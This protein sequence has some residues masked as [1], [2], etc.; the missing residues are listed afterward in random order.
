MKT[1]SE[2]EMYNL[3]INFAKKDERIRGVLLNGSRANPNIEKDIFQDYDIVYLVTKVEPFKDEKYILSHFGEIMIMQKPEDKIWRSPI[4]DGRYTYLLQ[5][6]DGNRIDMQI[7]NRENV[8]DFIEDSLTKVLL[9]KDKNIHYISP[10][11]EK[12]YFINKPTEKLYNDCCNS[13]IWGLGSH[14]PK[15]IWREELPLLKSLI[16]K[17]L[18]EPLIQMLKWQVGIKTN[19]EC[20]IGKGGKNLKKY[21]KPEIWNKYKKTYADYNFDNIWNSLFKLHE[22]F[23]KLAKQVAD[24]Y[25]YCFPEKEYERAF[26]FLKH[27][28]KLPPDS[29]IIFNK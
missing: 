5:F 18:R 15:T 27:V 2:K 1:R 29:K 10:P 22:L 28:K 11:S 4:G 24:K 16:N 23:K 9:D 17:V 3:I 6:I 19:Y 20:T 12:S 26:K 14:I 13:F 21:L 25:D 8:D 7:I